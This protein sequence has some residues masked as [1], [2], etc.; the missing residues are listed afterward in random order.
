MFDMT[1][2]WWELAVR[3][4]LVYIAVLIMVRLSGK[5]TIGEFSPFDVIV[6]LLVAEA[7]GGSLRGSDES[8]QGGLFIVAILILLNYTIAFISTRSRKVDAIL[9][10]LEAL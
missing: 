2:S 1:V 9:T 7:A 5:R 10:D 4:A 8:V 6:L 3:G